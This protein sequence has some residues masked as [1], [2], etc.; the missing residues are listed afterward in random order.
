MVFR[1]DPGAREFIAFWL[2][3]GRVMAGMNLNI[4]DVTHHNQALI[5]SREQVDVAR[6]RDPE[7]PTRGAGETS[8]TPH[9]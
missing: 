3:Q 4:G 9:P 7:V 1:R 5:R 6:L 2:A 8:G